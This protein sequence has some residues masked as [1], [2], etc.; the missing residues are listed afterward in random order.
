MFDKRNATIQH[1]LKLSEKSFRY[2]KNNRWK[3]LNSC[4]R[5][6]FVFW[7]LSKGEAVIMN[8]FQKKIK[9]GKETRKN[10]NIVEYGGNITKQ[11]NSIA[12]KNNDQFL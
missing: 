10:R 3:V 7:L 6:M 11:H 2:K 12:N 5:S 1:K 4:L 9:H 8:S